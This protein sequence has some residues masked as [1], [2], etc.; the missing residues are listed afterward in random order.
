[1]NSLKMIKEIVKQNVNLILFPKVHF[2]LFS[3]YPGLNPKRYALT[4]DN[5]YIQQIQRTCKE[6]AIRV[7]YIKEDPL[8]YVQFPRNDR[9]KIIVKSISD[10]N[11]RIVIDEIQKVECI[12]SYYMKNKLSL[13]EK[14]M[15]WKLSLEGILFKNKWDSYFEK[16]RF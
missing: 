11:L 10:K 9:E 12:S 7:G 16:E 6:Y 3:W 5:D 1:M 13:M 15:L 8:L 2:S 4:I 14:H